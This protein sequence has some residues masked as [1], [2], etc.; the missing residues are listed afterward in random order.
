MWNGEA[1]GRRRGT[2][3]TLERVSLA[4][5]AAEAGEPG[6]WELLDDASVR[7]LGVHGESLTRSVPYAVA[8][9][10]SQLAGH[11]RS[12]ARRAAVRL[13]QLVASACPAE[14]LATLW[15]LTHDGSRRVRQAAAVALNELGG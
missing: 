12:A 11:P 8:R 6:A 3:D 9:L 15:R 13:V 4:L 1:L 7:A 14:A 5:V 10:A 2:E